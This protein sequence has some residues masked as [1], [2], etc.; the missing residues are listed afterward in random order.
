[1]SGKA[2]PT[3]IEI[4]YS[5]T[6]FF[7]IELKLFFWTFWAFGSKKLQKTACLSVCVFPIWRP[8]ALNKTVCT[9][10]LSADSYK[11]AYASLI[12]L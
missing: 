2:P 7:S 8:F 11:I 6:L 12:E 3:D 1:M 5:R 4:E 9:P 10:I